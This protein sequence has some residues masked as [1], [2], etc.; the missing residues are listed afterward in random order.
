M[1]GG[2]GWCRG[3]GSMQMPATVCGRLTNLLQHNCLFDVVTS[4]SKSSSD[5]ADYPMHKDKHAL[6]SAIIMPC[7]CTDKVAWQHDVSSHC[8]CF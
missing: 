3:V 6:Q 1:N 4:A 7:C 5:I 8:M 2:R